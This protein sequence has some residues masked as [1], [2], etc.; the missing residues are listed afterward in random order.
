MKNLNSLLSAAFVLL[1]LTVASSAQAQTPPVL[2]PTYQSIHDNIF[3][4]KCMTCHAAG[5]EA[6]DVPLEPFSALI[7]Q[8]D[9][10][11][12]G[13]SADSS[14]YTTTANGKMP[15]QSS[16]LAALTPVEESTLKSW[17]DAG[18]VGP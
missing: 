5:Q 7:A 13:D 12:P 14:L 18:A 17:I 4:P 1:I 15:K 16:G 2:T 10:L 11:A 6:E 8:K 9:V 3:V